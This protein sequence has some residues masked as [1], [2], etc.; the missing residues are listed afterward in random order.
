MTQK[1]KIGSGVL[2]PILFSIR[3][4]AYFGGYAPVVLTNE[5]G[6]FL[7]THLDSN[8]VLHTNSYS[9]PKS[10]FKVFNYRYTSASILDF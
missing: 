7:L 5:S 6:S 9:K 2:I 10:S 1:Q 8:L 4:L 3:A